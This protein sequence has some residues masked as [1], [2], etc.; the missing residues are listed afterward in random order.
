MSALLGVV[1]SIPICI[2][3]YKNQV[4]DAH[5]IETKPIESL[6]SE[7][8]FSVI[9]QEIPETT[10]G[11][12]IEYV[13]LGEFRITAYCSCK[14]CCDKWA[15][16]RPLDENGNPIV[17]GASGEVLIPEYSVAVDPTV[18]PYGTK[19]YFNG[20]EY[21]AHDCGRAIKGNEIDLYFDSHEDALEWG[22]QYYEIFIIK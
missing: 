10:R 4:V 14:K 7:I 8:E 9:V 22:V 6:S 18:I 21:I 13:S 12:K 15:D 3:A 19:L 1:I 20:N 5:T 11:P 16:S 17:Y 2:G